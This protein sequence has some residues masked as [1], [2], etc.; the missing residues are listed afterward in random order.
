MMSAAT[1]TPTSAARRSEARACQY[2]IDLIYQRSGIRLHEGKEALIRARL[3]KRVRHLGLADL[4]QY[5]DYLQT[6]GT[7][8][9]F[10]RVVDALTTNFTSFLREEAHF[11][12]LVDEAL[13]SLA[14]STGAKIRIWSAASSS[15]E[16]PYSIA[17]Y[18]AEYFPTNRGWDWHITASDLS[19]RVLETARLGIYSEDR[20]AG[21]PKEW[22]RRYLQIGAGKWAGNYRIKK[23]ISER[24]EFSQ[25]NLIDSYSHA[26]P[27]QV[28]FCRNVM[29]YFDRPTQQRL[30]QH[31]ARFL[32]PK[33]ILLIGHSESL[34]G[35]D[36]PLHCLGPSIYRRT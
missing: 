30:V 31:L 17:F 14:P 32:V 25:I 6:S 3:G 4:S 23:C 18:L 22:L 1:T 11:K 20:L 8:E 7:D 26:H 13:P 28:I 2:I 24:V 5:C 27:F 10:V 34:N 29:I 35:L 33:G 15:G 16:E 19:V 12:Y 21:L 36:V 9:E